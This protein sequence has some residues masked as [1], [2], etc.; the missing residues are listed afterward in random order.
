MQGLGDLGFGQVS[1]NRMLTDTAEN[2]VLLQD[3]QT[4]M[5]LL[6]VQHTISVGSLMISQSILLSFFLHKMQN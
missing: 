2:R 5:M 4:R 3:W 6:E 1:A